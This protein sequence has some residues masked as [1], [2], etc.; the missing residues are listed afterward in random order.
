MRKKSTD[1]RGEE[2]LR[3]KELSKERGEREKMKVACTHL[4]WR[5]G[6]HTGRD[7]EKHPR[8]NRINR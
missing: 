6:S 4:M 8:G 1:R 7:E 2:K 3:H 5:D